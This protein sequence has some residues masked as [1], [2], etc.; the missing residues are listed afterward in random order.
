MENR[1]ELTEDDLTAKLV[2]ESS[3]YLTSEDEAPTITEI[4]TQAATECSVF[5]FS[6]G[7]SLVKDIEEITTIAHENGVSTV[8]GDNEIGAYTLVDFYYD[9]YDMGYRAGKQAQRILVKGEDPADI[10]VG[11]PTDS[12]YVKLYNASV[13]ELFQMNFPKSFSEF[14]EYLETYVPG[15]NTKRVTTAEAE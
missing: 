8:A 13:A 3:S 9:P 7:S 4:V 15:S 12:D 1:E 6:A 5:Y 14:H 11:L 2:S 10:K